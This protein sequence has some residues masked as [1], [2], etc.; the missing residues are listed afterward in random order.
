MNYLN[1]FHI[2]TRFENGELVKF[3]VVSDVLV[4]IESMTHNH[5][6]N[7]VVIT[8]RNKVGSF[9]LIHDLNTHT[10]KKSI[11]ELKKVG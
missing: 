5:D 11:I 6:C 1:N 7:Y 2:D 9:E 10:T 3:E 4:L 8:L